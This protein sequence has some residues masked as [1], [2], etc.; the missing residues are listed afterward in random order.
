MEQ[1]WV[2][3]LLLQDRK[4]YVGWTA[5]DNLARRIAQ[6]FCGNG[7]KWTMR[8][9]P[10]T[11]LAVTEGGKSLE[12]ATTAAMMARYGVDAVRGAGWCRLELAEPDW[13]KQARDY[14][15]W[16]EEVEKEEEESL[17]PRR[18]EKG[19]EEPNTEP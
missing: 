19:G 7:A 11:V 16:K 14:K 4:I 3:T 10:L 13:L 12:C 18:S 6:H 1:G 9:R 15:K 17:A 5:H 2:Y 8:H